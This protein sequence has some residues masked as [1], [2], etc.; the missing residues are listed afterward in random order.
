MAKQPDK[1]NGQ[2]QSQPQ[3][4][5]AKF[6][7]VNRISGELL[8]VEATSLDA[9]KDIVAAR[10]RNAIIE[11]PRHESQTNKVGPLLGKVNANRV[12]GHEPGT[13]KCV[14]ATGDGKPLFRLNRR[15][16]NNSKFDEQPMFGRTAKPIPLPEEQRCKEVEMPAGEII[17]V[18]A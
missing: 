15:G 13:L 16:W 5:I 1:M 3:P 11:L 4:A 12:N 7:L 18:E 9:A 6:Q 8:T 14:G 17:K 10:Y 2:Q